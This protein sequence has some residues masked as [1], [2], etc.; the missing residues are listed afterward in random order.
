MNILFD[1]TGCGL[2]NNGG[3]NTVV[4]SAEALR[5]L[6]YAVDVVARV[7]HYTWTKPSITP[8]PGHHSADVVV[9]VSVWDV[10]HALTFMVPTFWWVRGWETWVKGEGWWLAQLKKFT[11][12]GGRLIANAQHLVDRLAAHGFDATLC[13]AGL[14]LDTW[15]DAAPRPRECIMG[16]MKYNR[17]SSKRS[18]SMQQVADALL[19]KQSLLLDIKGANTPSQLREAYNCCDVWFAPTESEGFHNVAPEACLCGCLVVCNNLPSNGMGDWA[20]EET[21]MFYDPSDPGG[22]ITAIQRPDYGRVAKAQSVLRE[23]IGSRERNMRRFV[24]ILGG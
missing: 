23:K 17:H 1:A 10:D 6:G 19:P 8:G 15:E 5:G 7:N 24:E 16:A 14:D 4:R 22:A 13:Y 21:A 12:A 20:T 11:D 9:C 18:D 2:G 3:S